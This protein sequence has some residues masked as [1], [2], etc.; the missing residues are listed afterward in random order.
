MR[1]EDYHEQQVG[2]QKYV[3]GNKVLGENIKIL[4]TD[5]VNRK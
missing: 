4:K 5:K 3:Y 2:K 1:W